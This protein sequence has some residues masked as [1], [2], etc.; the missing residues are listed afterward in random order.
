MP[1]TVS[2]ET[3]QNGFHASVIL[4]ERNNATHTGFSTQQEAEHW[5]KV[6]S[7]KLQKQYEDVQKHCASH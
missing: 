7:K 3:S 4:T 1:V 6:M 2:V 5:S